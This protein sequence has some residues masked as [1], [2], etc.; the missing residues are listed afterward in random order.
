MLQDNGGMIKIATDDREI[1]INTNTKGMVVTKDGI[2][3]FDDAFKDIIEY[4]KLKSINIKSSCACEDYEAKIT[5][6]KY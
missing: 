5:F 3:N 6:H 4:I 2:S 1:S